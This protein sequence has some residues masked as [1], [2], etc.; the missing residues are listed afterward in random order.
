MKKK[1]KEKRETE[2]RL[3]VRNMCM[4]RVLGVSPTPSPTGMNLGKTL[5]GVAKSNHLVSLHLQPFPSNQLGVEKSREKEID[6]KN[7]H[8]VVYRSM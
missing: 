8:D 6:L 2:K 1:R 4:K 5:Y 7:L 3:H